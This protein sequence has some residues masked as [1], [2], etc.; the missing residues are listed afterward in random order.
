MSCQGTDCSYSQVS[1][2]ANFSVKTHGKEQGVI[3]TSVAE[4]LGQLCFLCRWQGGLGSSGSGRCCTECCL[5]PRWGNSINQLINM[6]S[7]LGGNWDPADK[8]FSSVNSYR[9]DLLP[10]CK[11]MT[12]L[13]TRQITWSHQA[14]RIQPMVA[15]H[16]WA[17]AQTW[18]SLLGL[19]TLV[20]L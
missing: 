12:C 19:P 20:L 14:S 17:G 8:K 11:C 9:Q 6:F 3:L 18:F 10:T 16:P 7:V 1:A 2:T 4:V 5:H 15:Q 13:L